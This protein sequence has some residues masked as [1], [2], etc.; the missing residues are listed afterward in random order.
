MSGLLTIGSLFSGIGLLDLGLE[1]AGLGPPKWQVEIDD[2]ARRVLAKHW[3]DAIRLCDVRAVNGCLVPRVDVLAGGF[4]CQD[5]SSAGRG[6][7]LSGR[8]SGLWFE[9][10]RIVRELR[11][12]FVIVENVAK[13]FTR[14]IDVVLGT[15]AESGY[16]SLWYRLAASDVG[17]PHRRHRVFIVAWRMANASSEREREPANETHAVAVAPWARDEPRDGREPLADDSFDGAES[18]RR[19]AAQAGRDAAAV[20]DS[21]VGNTDAQG[22]LQPNGRIEVFGRWARDADGRSVESAM[23]RVVDGRADWLDRSWPG[24][25]A[26]PGEE[27]L[28]WEPPRTLVGVANREDQIRGLGN[29]V[30]PQ[31]GYVAGRIVAQLAERGVA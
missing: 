28:E 7:G 1:W 2:Y 13:L 20:R 29:G 26:R 8:R 25:P 9:Y 24:W 10:L 18:R 15:L 19:Y 23:G 4:P 17:A 14:G 21:R 5:I 6:A 22:Q 3:P 11:P 31:C 12:R 30:V 16:D 27:Q